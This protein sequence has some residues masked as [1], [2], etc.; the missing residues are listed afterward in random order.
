MRT[1]LLHYFV[2]AILTS[3]SFSGIIRLPKQKVFEIILTSDVGAV[4]KLPQK[5]WLYHYDSLSFDW[6]K[7]NN[8]RTCVFT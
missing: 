3:F 5:N 1:I 6:W 7:V 4:T 8:I 2:A